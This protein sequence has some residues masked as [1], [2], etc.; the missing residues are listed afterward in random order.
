MANA[1]ANIK[2][3]RDQLP[4]VKKLPMLARDPRR[5]SE[6][7]AGRRGA[8]GAAAGLR[9]ALCWGVRAGTPQCPR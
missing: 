8:E 6:A 1:H 9:N 2:R 7:A 4:V 3:K 5:G